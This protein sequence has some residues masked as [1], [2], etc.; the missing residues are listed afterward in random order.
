MSASGPAGGIADDLVGEKQA[1]RGRMER[2]Y[3]KS[4]GATEDNAERRFAAARAR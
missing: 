1:R 4:T 2:S 3:L